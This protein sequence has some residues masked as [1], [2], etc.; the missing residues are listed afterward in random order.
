MP[1][2]T[3][4][5]FKHYYEDAG[6]G[7]ALIMMH[8]ANSSG[9]SLA[10]AYQELA[11]A[12]RVLVPDMRGLGRSEHVPEIP[13]GAW[14]EDILGLLDHL[15]VSTAY[16]YGVSLGARVALRFAIDH[17]D[18]VAALILDA[19]VIAMESGGSEA[20]QRLFDVNSLPAERKAQLRDTHGDDWEQVNTIYLKT[21]NNPQFQAFYDLRERSSSVSVPTLILR[22]DIDDAVHRIAHAVELHE[23]IQGSWLSVVPD[24]RFG[25]GIFAPARCVELIHQFVGHQ[26]IEHAG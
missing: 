1:E 10:G 21:R 15:G 6:S 22:G 16:V 5:A 23:R 9:R 20:V 3:I 14:N 17:P 11:K 4:N 12:F 19:P 18:R 2:T 13:P 7:P 24:T 26:Q 25:L 8:G